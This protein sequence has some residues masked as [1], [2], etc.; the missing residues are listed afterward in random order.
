MPFLSGG[1][2]KNIKRGKM[3]SKVTRTLERNPAN[4]ADLGQGYYWLAI[5][6]LQ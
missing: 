4:F 1:L 2:L 6:A 5:E 3:L